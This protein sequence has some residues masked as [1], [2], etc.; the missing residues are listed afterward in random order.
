MIEELVTKY[1][2]AVSKN[3]R[4]N[5]LTKLR[6]LDALKKEATALSK[7]GCELPLKGRIL[8]IK[9]CICT[10]EDT[11]TSSSKILEGYQSPFDATIVKLLRDAGAL[12]LGSTNMDEF[13]MGVSSNNE[14]FG[15]TVNPLY[16]H[17]SFV[18]GG[19]SGGAAAAVAAGMCHASI[20][21]DTGGSIRLPSAFTGVFGFKPTYGRIS[22]FGVIPFANS[23]DTIG[24]SGDSIDSV[25]RIFHVLNQ[26]DKNDL[27]CMTNNQRTKVDHLIKN[28]SSNEKPVVGI[29]TNW[30]VAEL[31]PAILDKWNECIAKLE[32]AGCTVK[33]VYLPNSSYA[34]NIYFA[35]AYAEGLSNLARYDGAM[36]GQ[37]LVDEETGRRLSVKEIR[38]MLVGEEV[39][40]RV[41]LGAYSLRYGS[42]K[43]LFKKA[44]QVRREIQREFNKA[45]RMQNALCHDDE[46][47][48]V[49]FIVAPVS[50]SFCPK[51]GASS[52]NDLITD[53][54]LI[55]AN[56]AGA[57]SM[58]VP[59]GKTPEGFDVGLQVIAQFGDDER[60]I[61]YSD[62]V[63]RLMNP[64]QENVKPTSKSAVK[65]EH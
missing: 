26:H 4:I 20:G 49:D 57:P 6:S 8:T 62:L 43:G 25:R 46:C 41:L 19:S 12:I 52:P 28:S 1:A 53:A 59:C 22:R 30:N 34:L 33:E 9:E 55:P 27:S 38:S 54:L 51:I 31:E 2:N 18:A 11:A 16:D 65:T 5:A 64:D 24:I 58:S 17:D 56:M 39:Q 37:H 32:E 47:G 7:I 23:L 44:Q 48:T 13:A 3:T 21:T 10:K 15:Q 61:Q 42:E 45:F 29:P 14:L 36:F 63:H 60:C 40:K 50:L 35:V